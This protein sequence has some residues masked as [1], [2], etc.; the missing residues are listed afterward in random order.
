MKDNEEHINAV[1]LKEYGLENEV[2]CEVSEKSI[3]VHRFL[4]QRRYTSINGW[5][6]LCKNKKR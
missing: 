5:K 4:I 3:S 1:I 6:L 2:A